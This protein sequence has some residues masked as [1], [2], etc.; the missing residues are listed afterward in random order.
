MPRRAAPPEKV[1]FRE[2]PATLQWVIDRGLNP[3][4]L[5]RQAFEAEVK[6]MK[7]DDWLARL[8]ELQKHMKP[9]STEDIVRAVRESREEH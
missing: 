2:D 9:V 1:Q 7:G 6:R 4:E 5:A 8:R 3:N